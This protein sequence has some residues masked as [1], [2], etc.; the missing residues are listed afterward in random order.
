[1]ETRPRIKITLS[2]LDTTLEYTGLLFLAVLW[3]LSVYVF[4]NS[5]VNVPTHFNF[6]G[7]V[8]GYGSRQTIFIL[9]VLGTV[10]FIGLTQLN[11][12]PHRFNYMTEITEKNALRQYT[13]ATRMLRYLKL[14]IPAVF[15][16]IVLVTYLTSLGA[17]KGLG[18]WLVS[19]IVLIFLIPAILVIYQSLKNKEKER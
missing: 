19:V 16:I 6:S 14:A 17:A 4:M 8:D 10:L 2:R 11:K 12:Y 5:P 15:S 13:L 3:A 18:F 1:M 9:P 7:K